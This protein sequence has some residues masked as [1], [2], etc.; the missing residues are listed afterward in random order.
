MTGKGDHEEESDGEYQPTDPDE[1]TSSIPLIGM[2]LTFHTPDR[3][4]SAISTVT[5]PN[6]ATKVPTK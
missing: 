1:L 4:G 5:K 6:V 3:D 2:E